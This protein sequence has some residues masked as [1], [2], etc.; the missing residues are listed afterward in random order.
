MIATVLLILATWL[1]LGCAAS[2]VWLTWR[3]R[4]NDRRVRR[5]AFDLDAELRDLI[6]QHRT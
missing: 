3:M 4:C 1:V 6:E 5:Y 2:Y